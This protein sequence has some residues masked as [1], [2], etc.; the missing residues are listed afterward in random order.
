MSDRARRSPRVLSP[1]EEELLRWVVQHSAAEPKPYLEQIPKLRVVGYCGCGCPTVD[2]AL[3]STARSEAIGYP[4]AE[5][6]GHSPEGVYVGVIVFANDGV[7]SMLEV[8]S[9]TG[10]GGPYTLPR[11]EALTAAPP[12]TWPRPVAEL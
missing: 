10:E 9:V 6:D 12:T 2:L 4:I 3:A 11:P 1:A 5:A 7:L 8:Y